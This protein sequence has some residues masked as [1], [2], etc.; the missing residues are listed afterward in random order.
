MLKSVRYMTS[1]L[2]VLSFF[3]CWAI[4]L[5]ANADVPECHV[6]DGLPNVGAKLQ[7]GET[8]KVA[9]LGGSITCQAGYRVKSL[10]WLQEQ[11]PEAEIEEI[12]AG[13]G[14]TPSHL[15]AYRFG[16]DVLR[17]KPDLLF[18]EFAVNDSG[19][20]IEDVLRSME[21]IVRQTWKADIT[22]DIVFVYTIRSGMFEELQQ[23]RYQKA[24]CAHEE[25]A[26]YYNIPSVHMGCMAAKLEEEGKLIV[27]GD[28]PPKDVDAMAQTPIVFSADG[29]HPFEETGHEL[30]MQALERSLPGSFASGKPG[31]RF[32]REP[33]RADCREHAKMVPL[34]RD[35]MTG[36]WRLLSEDDP[37]AR[38]FARYMPNLWMAE[39]PGAKLTI[40]FRGT[41]IGFYDLIAPEAGQ[42]ILRLDGE[43]LPV[44]PRFDKYA[45]YSR[46]SSLSVGKDLEDG[47]HVLEAE[48]H[49][50]APDKMAILAPERREQFD[51]SNLDDTC[52]YVGAIM[53]EGEILPA[54]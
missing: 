23:G 2:A 37:T 38:K 42:I 17:H 16:Q 13:I 35:M 48:I 49:P 4:V 30:Y 43:E 8:V 25:V 45:A 22:T 36:D 50:E 15:G 34:S 26:D 53:I 27:Q 29:V 18:V 5:H 19:S 21:G 12:F 41:H 1:C 24:A 28:R 40:R 39:T 31:S 10:A 20:N 7:A 54:E 3:A 11:Y 51:R 6:R 9:Y 32:L 14:G 33:M 52:W 46:I 44:R 47:V